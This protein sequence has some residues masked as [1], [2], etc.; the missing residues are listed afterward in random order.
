MIA[1]LGACGGSEGFPCR[2]DEAYVVGYDPNPRNG[3]RGVC[4][5]LDD[6]VTPEGMQKLDTLRRQ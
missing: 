4:V 1:F 2:E 3:L 5:V 6:F